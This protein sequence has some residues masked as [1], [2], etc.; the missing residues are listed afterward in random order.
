MSLGL[1][2]LVK[3]KSSDIGKSVL[4][5]EGLLEGIVGWRR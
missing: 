3:E 1:E 4:I 5:F 2:N